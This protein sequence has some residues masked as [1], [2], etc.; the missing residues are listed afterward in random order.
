MQMFR[1]EWSPQHPWEKLGVGEHWGGSDG[2]VTG[3]VGQS[4]ETSF[5][6]I[7]SLLRI[8]RTLEFVLWPTRTH[9]CTYMC[10]HCS[11]HMHIC[12]ISYIFKRSLCLI[13]GYTR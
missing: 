12:K 1:S 6:R 9:A 7:L 13:Y 2:S 3:L 10:A 5:S 11:M 8:L 4:A